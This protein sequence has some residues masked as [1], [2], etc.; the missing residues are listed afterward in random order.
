MV[1]NELITELNSRAD[2]Y[3]EDV[4]LTDTETGEVT[5]GHWCGIDN[6]LIEIEH[7]SESELYNIFR[8]RHKGS[9]FMSGWIL[10]TADKLDEN[11]YLLHTLDD[12]FKLDFI[13]VK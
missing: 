3:T 2:Y 5:V 10:K 12:M 11:T 9:R 13:G 1:D 6:E 4:W 8:F 7:G